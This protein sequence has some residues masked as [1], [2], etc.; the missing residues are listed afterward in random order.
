MTGHGHGHAGGHEHAQLHGPRW[1]GLTTAIVLGIAAVFAGVATWRAQVMQGHSV[2]HFTLSTQASSTANTLMQDAERSMSSE[3]QLFIDYRTALERNDT[4]LATTVLS[5]MTANSRAAITWWK[6]QPAIDRPYTPFVS[7]NPEWNAPG[8]IID[9]KASLEDSA[10]Y[11][12]LAETE[13]GRS[14][15]L[16]FVAAFLTIAFLA[17]GLAGTFESMRMR[18]G[19]LAVSVIVLVGCIGGAVAFW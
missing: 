5:M 16:E 1:L 3:R 14:H 18:I 10:H 19:L 12:E 17:G 11:L 9:A 13:L 6:A 2:E 7:A 8:V 15:D 4:Q